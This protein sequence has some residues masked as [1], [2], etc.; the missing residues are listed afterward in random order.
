L[1]LQ[2]LVKQRKIEGIVLKTFGAGNIPNNEYWKE[3]ITNCEENNVIVL[4]TTQCPNGKIEIGQYAAS[5]LL[6]S[7]CVV[8]GNDITS[9]AAL[10]KLM[11]VIGNFE[12][13]VRTEMLSKNLR[14]EI[15]YPK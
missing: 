14:G 6:D 9:E 15:S 13:K 8:K 3:L 11:W 12:P 1:A 4:A 7:S 5:R 10:T 2:E